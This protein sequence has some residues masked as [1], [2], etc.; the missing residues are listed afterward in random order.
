[1][2]DTFQTLVGIL[3]LPFI[4]AYILVMSLL[5]FIYLYPKKATLVMMHLVALMMVYFLIQ[6]I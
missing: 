1:M 5:G 2:K 6:C 4:I 3:V